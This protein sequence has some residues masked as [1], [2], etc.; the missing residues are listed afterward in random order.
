KVDAAQVVD[1]RD[2]DLDLVADIDDVFDRRYAVVGQL[3]NA[4]EAFLAGHNLDK[5]A[6]VDGP[7]DTAGVNLSDDRLTR[8][9]LDHGDGLAGVL[10]VAGADEHRAVVF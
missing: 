6:E 4:D 1:F 10:F 7:G 5:G 2:H 8:Q 9:A 3:A